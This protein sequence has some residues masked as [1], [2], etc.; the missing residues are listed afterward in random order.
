[1]DSGSSS[2]GGEPRCRRRAVIS[3]DIGEHCPSISRRGD[4]WLEDCHGGS[5]P[6]WI[7]FDGGTIDWQA[8]GSTTHVH[9]GSLESDHPPVSA[10][11][12][13][14]VTGAGMMLRSKMVRS[15]GLLPDDWFLYFE[16]TAYNV[17]A[18]RRGWRT[19]INPRFACAIS[20][21]LRASSPRGTTSTT[22]S[23]N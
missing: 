7:W 4:R 15:V 8:A 20:K 22:S 17:L 18:K 16:E 23:G 12:V 11:D 21:G 1:M 13:D 9:M 14:Y 5:E 2:P 19:M 10:H 3:R 6:A